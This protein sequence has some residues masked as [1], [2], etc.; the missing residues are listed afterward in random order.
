MNEFNFKKIEVK[1]KMFRIDLIL[2]N[3]I[4]KKKKF[5]K[6]I[7]FVSFSLFELKYLIYILLK[8]YYN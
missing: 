2:Y 1:R 7:N 4:C 5:K 8:L 3:F 6:F